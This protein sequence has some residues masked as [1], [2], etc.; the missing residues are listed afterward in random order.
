MS[1][2][3][4]RRP[5]PRLADGELAHLERRPVDAQLALRQWHGYV[6]AFADRGWQ[7]TEVTPLDEHPDGV[8]VEDTVV[9]LGDLAVL[10]APG[11]PSRRGEVESTAAALA[12]LGIETARI[13]EPGHLDGGD[14]LK[15]GTTVYVG[16]SARTDD[17]GIRQLVRLAA[18]RGRQ[19]IAVPV[20]KVLHLKSGVTALPDGTVIGYEPL[21]DEPDAF[22]KF[23]PVPEEHGTAVVALDDET[24][25][26]SAGAPRT[27]ELFASRDLDVIAVPIS[28]FEKLEGCVTCL[29]VRIRQPGQSP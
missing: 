26:M 13:T 11:A 20:R 25:L 1:R 5:S 8:F 3:L 19:V 24:V 14:V 23:L 7:V 21:V 2:I 10:T 6:A 16:R 18:T 29:S 9:M 27:A 17:E 28:E 4:V 12:Q 22:E 15:I